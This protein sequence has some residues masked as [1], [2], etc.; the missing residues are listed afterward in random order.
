LSTARPRGG[1]LVGGRSERMGRPKAELLFEGRR[2]DAIAEAALAPHCG[3][4]HR[5]GADGLVDAP[6]LVGPLAGIVAARSHAPAA[7]WVVVACDM[8]L[9]TPEAV[10]WL[11]AARCEGAVAVL[12][13][14]E[15]GGPQPTLA[16]Y[17]PGVDPLLASVTAPVQLSG[18]PGVLTPPV[19]TALVQCWT[20]VNRPEELA[21]LAT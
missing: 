18:L 19:P 11:L 7:W 5:L 1:I 9:V 8:P 17:G 12:P 6:G 4:I 10:R 15:S 16:L 14:T 13:T 3:T 2:L 21:A 20:N